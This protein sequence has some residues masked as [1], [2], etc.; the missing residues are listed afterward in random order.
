M[1]AQ[2]NKLPV[3]HVD[4]ATALVT[5]FDEHLMQQSTAF[6]TQLRARDIATELWME[7]GVKLEKQLKYAD[8]KQIPYVII[9]GPDEAA[10]QMV[11]IKSLNE[12]TQQTLP[13]DEAVSFLENR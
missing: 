1:L 5:V 9:I 11:V 2:C 6:S 12:R 8:Q 7:P 13:I 3:V 10:R 4:N